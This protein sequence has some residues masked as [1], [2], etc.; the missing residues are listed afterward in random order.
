MVGQ[1]AGKRKWF[2]KKYIRFTALVT[3]FIYIYS[4]NVYNNCFTLRHPP[5]HLVAAR[6]RYLSPP[7]WAPTAGRLPPTRS[8]G[9]ERPR[10]PGL[11]SCFSHPPLDL[12]AR[13][14]KRMSRHLH[15]GVGPV[16]G[17][18]KLKSQ[19][20]NQSVWEMRISLYCWAVMWGRCRIFFFVCVLNA[21]AGRKNPAPTP[22]NNI[23]SK[24]YQHLNFTFFKFLTFFLQVSNVRLKNVRL[25]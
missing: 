11:R 8:T 17:D 3:I 14:R 6:Y 13:P 10:R 19:S 15:H 12:L 5:G 20:V 23:L 1:R 16:E 4:I 9:A 22:I 21:G 24:V 18:W 7:P 2:W 25:R